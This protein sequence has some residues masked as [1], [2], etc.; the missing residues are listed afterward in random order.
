MLVLVIERGAEQEQRHHAR[1]AAVGRCINQRRYARPAC[2]NLHQVRLCVFG[3]QLKESNRSL[4]MTKE[5]LSSELYLSKA[6]LGA[7]PELGALPYLRRLPSLLSLPL[8]L[9]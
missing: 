5:V 7:V 3:K 8:L 2:L 1:L 6:L 4:I 9:S